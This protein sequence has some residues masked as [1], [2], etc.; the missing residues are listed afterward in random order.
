MKSLNLTF[1]D[2]LSLKLTDY[3]REHKKTKSHVIRKALNEYLINVCL[4][5]GCSKY[6]CDSAGKFKKCCPDC[7]HS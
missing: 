2:S 5:C 4:V 7:S 1:S 6:K 3:V